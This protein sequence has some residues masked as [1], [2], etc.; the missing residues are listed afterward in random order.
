MTIYKLTINEVGQDPLVCVSS[1]VNPRTEKSVEY[2][3]SE[4]KAKARQT[5]IYESSQKL[6]GFL[7]KIEV[8]IKPIEVIE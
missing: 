4:E 3:K 7:P 8:I 1:Y 2:Y 5:E 6:L